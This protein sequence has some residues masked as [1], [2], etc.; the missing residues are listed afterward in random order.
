MVTS[1][2]NLSFGFEESLSLFLRPALMGYGSAA[3]TLKIIL[4]KVNGQATIRLLGELGYIYV[5]SFCF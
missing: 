3:D 1:N 5:D 2:D 4:F